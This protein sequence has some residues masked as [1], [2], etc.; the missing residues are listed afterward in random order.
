MQD[1]NEI[2]LQEYSVPELFDLID[3]KVSQVKSVKG[4]EKNSLRKE[5]NGLMDYVE[6]RIDRKIYNRL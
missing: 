6:K 3:E 2:P 4:K 5:I 1:Q